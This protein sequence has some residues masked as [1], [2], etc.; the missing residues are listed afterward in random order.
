MG[1]SLARLEACVAFEEW[2]KR[3]PDYEVQADGASR[4]H[5]VNMR[6]FAALPIK[7]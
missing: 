6:G 5:S 1:A 7:V 2:W 4:V 3:F